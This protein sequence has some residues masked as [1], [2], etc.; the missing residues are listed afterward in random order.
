[1]EVEKKARGPILGQDQFDMY[2]TQ[3]LLKTLE[4]EK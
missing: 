2:Q 3:N 4:E 1:M